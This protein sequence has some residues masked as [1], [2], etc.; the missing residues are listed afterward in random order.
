[1]VSQAAGPALTGSVIVQFRFK[2]RR[3]LTASLKGWEVGGGGPAASHTGNWLSAWGSTQ[4][5]TGFFIQNT[6][7]LLLLFLPLPPSSPRREMPL[8]TAA[9]PHP[10]SI[11]TLPG[12]PISG[13]TAYNRVYVSVC[14]R[15]GVISLSLG[16][17]RHLPL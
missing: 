5:E 15:E 10:V 7:F 6:L 13:L 17:S 16:G 3:A 8:T 14:L 12:R 9:A 4:L 1:M 11:H 2:T